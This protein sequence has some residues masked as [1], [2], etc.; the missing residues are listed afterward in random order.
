M[1]AHGQKKEEAR[2]RAIDALAAKQK[3]GDEESA[4]KETS[5]TCKFKEVAPTAEPSGGEGEESV[6]GM[7]AGEVLAV[8]GTL[9]GGQR[10]LN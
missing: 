8:G 9:E 10:C 3:A 7:V 1:Q 2:K 4:Q 6:L 5:K